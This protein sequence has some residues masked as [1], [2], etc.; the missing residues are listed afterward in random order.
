MLIVFLDFSTN[1]I[2]IISTKLF[3]KIERSIKNIL[4]LFF[5]FF[6]PTLQEKVLDP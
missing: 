6:F 2:K 5:I 1:I 4:L 3:Y